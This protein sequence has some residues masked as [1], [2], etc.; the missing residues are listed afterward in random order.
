MSSK[1]F[2]LY[3]KETQHLLKLL[4]EMETIPFNFKE[5]ILPLR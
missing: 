3:Y 2:I 4:L 1:K 5:F